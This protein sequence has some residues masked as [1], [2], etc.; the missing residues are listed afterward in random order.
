MKIN[1]SL[2][3]ML[4]LLFAAIKLHAQDNF[5]LAE[6]FDDAGKKYEKIGRGECHVTNG[7]LTTKDAYLSFGEY[8]WKNYEVKFRARVPETAE[9]VQIC[10]GFRAANRDDRYI[11]AHWTFSLYPASGMISRFSWQ[12]TGSGYF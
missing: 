9:Q 6:N 1:N 8:S 12:V 4:L 10:A 5:K 7:V 3:V 2:K 11:C